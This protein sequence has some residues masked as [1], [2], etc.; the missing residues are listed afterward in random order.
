M[1]W[2]SSLRPEQPEQKKKK[3]EPKGFAGTVYTLG[4]DLLYVLAA[5]IVV[6]T[7]FARLTGVHGTS[8]NPTLY[9]VDD[10]GK[11]SGDYLILLS[12][13]LYSD[14]RQGDIV[15]AV[16]PSFDETKPIVKRVIATPG[17]TIEVK[18]AQ[19][20]DGT[21]VYHVYV[22]GVQQDESFVNG[23]RMERN[24]FQGEGSGN[25]LSLNKPV[26]VPENCYFLMGDNRDNSHDSRWRDIGMVDRQYIVG[27]A[28]TI[29]LPGGE[30][31]RD[32]SRIFSLGRK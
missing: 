27:K 30:G 9:G 15:V 13:V 32:W 29:I 28:L 3:D 4:H 25:T 1:E 23:G 6:F 24:Y 22:D 8:M 10:N 2:E 19:D 31:Q 11:G 20:D 17:Q 26:T 21:T 5:V 18:Q 14:Y 12:N 16:V 7:F